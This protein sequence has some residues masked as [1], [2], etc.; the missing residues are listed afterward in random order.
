[1]WVV[2]LD[3]DPE[4]DVEREGCELDAWEGVVDVEGL[5]DWT[6]ARGG[7]RLDDLDAMDRLM[8]AIAAALRAEVE[9]WWTE[10]TDVDPLVLEFASVTHA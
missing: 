2:E 7:C 1:L 5:V 10:E 3:V 8:A 9:A 4:D 6:A